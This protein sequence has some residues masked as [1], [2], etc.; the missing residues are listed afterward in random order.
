M[1][2]Q[3]SVPTTSIAHPFSP[4]P[5]RIF[6]SS[7]LKSHFGENQLFKSN[8]TSGSFTIDSSTANEKKKPLPLIFVAYFLSVCNVLKI[9]VRLGVATGAYPASLM[10]NAPLPAAIS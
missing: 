7:W 1:L 10:A 2:G 6:P 8:L 4:Y 3:Y 9:C 5:Y